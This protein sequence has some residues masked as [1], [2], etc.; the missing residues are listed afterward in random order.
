MAKAKTPSTALTDDT[1]PALEQP[2]ED[3]APLAQDLPPDTEPREEFA[4][5]AE[6]FASRAALEAA[7]EPEAEHGAVAREVRRLYGF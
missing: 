6:Y 2:T 1:L 7:Q 3:V 5:Q 4:S